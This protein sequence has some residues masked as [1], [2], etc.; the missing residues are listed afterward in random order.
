MN[1]L[2]NKPKTTKAARTK[3]FYKSKLNLLF[4]FI[5][6]VG[7]LVINDP[8]IIEQLSPQTIGYITTAIG[9][10]GTITRTF[11]TDSPIE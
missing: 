9:I 5:A 7:V 4:T 1:E 6:S 11:F 10:L 2:N 8:L 3:K